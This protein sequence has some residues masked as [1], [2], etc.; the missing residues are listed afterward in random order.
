MS[1][2][3][4]SEWIKALVTE[5]ERDVVFVFN[6]A[7][8]AFGGP[9]PDVATPL[10]ASIGQALIEHGCIAG[11]GDPDSP[12]W[13]VPVQLQ[14]HHEQLPRVISTLLKEHPDEFEFLAFARR[15][16]NSGRA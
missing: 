3:D 11:F 7:A 4:E 13:Q 1:T 14:V 2:F 15:T 10:V 9:T 16:G 5:A 6:I 12:E 8:G